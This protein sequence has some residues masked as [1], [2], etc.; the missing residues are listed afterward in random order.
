MLYLHEI[1]LI[2]DTRTGLEEKAERVDGVRN[3][4]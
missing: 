3:I 4:S 1:P 2:T